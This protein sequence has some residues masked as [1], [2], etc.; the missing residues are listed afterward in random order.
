MYSATKG[1]NNIFSLS[2]GQE[3]GDKI[4]IIVM[5]PNAV[6]TDSY[7]VFLYSILEIKKL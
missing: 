7:I 5:R 4:D 1:F 6:K 2:L 3:V